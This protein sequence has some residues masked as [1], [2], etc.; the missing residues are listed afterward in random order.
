M[1]IQEIVKKWLIDNGY[2]GL[3]SE[4]CC[5]CDISTL[6]DCGEPNNCEAGYKVPC[7]PNCG[8]HKFHIA[9]EKG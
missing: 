6:M 3:Y 2:D 8:E 7:P 5:G 4:G 9:K 1:I